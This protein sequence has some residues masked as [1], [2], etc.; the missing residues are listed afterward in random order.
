MG[1]LRAYLDDSGTHAGS[2]ITAVAG[3]VATIS[4][5]EI[6][7]DDWAKALVDD[8]GLSG[9]QT[10]HA[11]DCEHGHGEFSCVPRGLREPMSRRLATII[12]SREIYPIWSAVINEEWDEIT[13]EEFRKEFP[14][15]FLL[16]FRYCINEISKW[17]FGKAKGSPTELIFSEQNDHAN[18]MLSIFDLYRQK[19]TTTSLSTLIFDSP[20]NCTPLQ[21][22]DFLAYEVNRYWDDLGYGEF[23]NGTHLNFREN[24]IRVAN[25]RGMNNGGCYGKL[26][27]QNVVRNFHRER[28]VN[29]GTYKRIGR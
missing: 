11:V 6:V 15:P 13:D 18:R 5:W 3:F 27:L 26:G 10:F 25:A 9:V 1:P 14:K 7:E 23:G 12:T 24:S 2:R 4:E 22:A 20:V 16:C 19:R 28:V 29:S 8:F 21:S 17:A